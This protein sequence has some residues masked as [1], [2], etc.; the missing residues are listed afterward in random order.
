[1]PA[2]FSARLKLAVSWFTFQVSQ[3]TDEQDCPRSLTRTAV[4]VPPLPGPFEAQPGASVFVT[5]FLLWRMRLACFLYTGLLEFLLSAGRFRR[6]QVSV[7]RSDNSD[8]LIGSFTSS[9][10]NTSSSSASTGS[11]ERDSA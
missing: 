5:P 2:H 11:S 6:F 3:F 9:S 7:F 10:W 1:M 8:A 4:S